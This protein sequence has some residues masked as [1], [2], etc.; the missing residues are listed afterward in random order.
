V[1]VQ[2]TQVAQ[3]TEPMAATAAA[4]ALEEAAVV[5]RRMA[6]PLAT[7]VMGHLVLSL[8]PLIFDL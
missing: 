8:L 6:R 7:A 5:R 2:E 1:V 4:M 3:P